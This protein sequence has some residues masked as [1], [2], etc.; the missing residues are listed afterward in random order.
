MSAGLSKPAIA[1][2][3]RRIFRKIAKEYGGQ[4]VPGTSYTR[5]FVAGNAPIWNIRARVIRASNGE[6]C[7][8]FYAIRHYADGR[9]ALTASR[10]SPFE[11]LAA[12]GI[13]PRSL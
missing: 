12:V 7:L 13:K 9:A 10:L 1:A 2:A 5:P 11:A 4:Y 6:A 3:Y 8:S